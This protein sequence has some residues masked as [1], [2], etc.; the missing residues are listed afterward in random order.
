M[1]NP[2]GIKV[3]P[4]DVDK[5][6]TS[7]VKLFL[8]AHPEMEGIHISRRFMFKKIVKFYIEND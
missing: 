2:I 1:K 3:D 4:E 6:M 7:C 8:K 5:M